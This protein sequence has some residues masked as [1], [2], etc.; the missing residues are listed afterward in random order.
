MSSI[1]RLLSRRDKYTHQKVMSSPV[2]TPPHVSDSSS[3]SSSTTSTSTSPPVQFALSHGQKFSSSL[4]SLSLAFTT[5]TPKR[6]PSLQAIEGT[7]HA[8]TANAFEHLLLQPKQT[9]GH[10]HG[11]FPD[12][13]TE[14]PVKDD[15]TKVYHMT[16]LKCRS[17]V[18]IDQTFVSTPCPCWLHKS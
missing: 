6:S 3:I 10:L 13:E 1:N 16:T 17:L 15:E 14:A 5:Q 7:I 2:P 12:E 9:A 4:S 8:S 11:L 18:D